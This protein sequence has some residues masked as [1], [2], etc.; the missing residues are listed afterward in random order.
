MT[1][2]D[3]SRIAT[4]YVKRYDGVR[5][6]QGRVTTEDDYNEGARL[7]AEHARQ[8]VLDVVGPSGSPDGGFGIDNPR[9]NAHG[10]LDFDIGAGV[11]YL[12]GLRLECEGEIYTQQL[13][14]LEQLPAERAPPASGRADLV[15]LMAWEQPVCAV[16][17]AELFE[18]ALGGPDT[19]TRTRLMRRVMLGAG[20]GGADCATAWSAALGTIEKTYGAWDANTG[21]CEPDTTLQVGFDNAGAK[22]D[23]CSPSVAGGYL[24]AE[25][26]AIRVQ[27]V[28]SSHITWGF[29][30]ASPLYR[31]TVGADP[32]IITLQTEPKDQAHWM[33]P[34]QTVEILA[35]SALLPNGEKLAETTGFLTTVAGGYDPDLHTLKLSTAVPGMPPPGFGEQW[36]ARDDSADLA[37]NGTY[38][39][40]RVWPRGS[41]T[42]SPAALPFATKAPVTLGHTG[43]Q[44]TLDGSVFVPGDFWVIAARPEDPSRVVPWDLLSGRKPQGIRRFFAPL[45]QIFW[46]VVAGDTSATTLD[47]CR[48]P[49][50][51]LTRRQTCCT[52]TVGDGIVSHG[53]YAVIQD[54]I[55]H[56]PPRGGCICIFAGTYAQDFRIDGRSNVRIEGCGPRTHITG[57][58]QSKNRAV[59]SIVDSSDI[60]LTDLAI[61]HAVRIPLQLVD[62]LEVQ[63]LTLPPELATVQGNA[64][65]Q[66]G[67][68]LTRIRLR[69]LTLESRDMSALVMAGGSVIDLCESEITLDALPFDFQFKSNAGRWPGIFIAADD[70]KVERNAIQA[71]S[72]TQR[73]PVTFVPPGAL[74]PAGLLLTVLARL[75]LGGIQIAGGSERVL[76]RRNAIIGG[77]GNG[78]TLGSI[79]YVPALALKAFIGKGDFLALSKLWTPATL[80]GHLSIDA[81]GCIQ[82]VPDP[83]PPN[84]PDGTPLVPVST[85]KLTDIVIEENDIEQMGLSGIAVARFFDM[86]GFAQ[87]ILVDRLTIRLNRIS[88]CLRVELPA[89]TGALAGWAAYGAIALALADDLLVQGNTIN[90]NGHSHLQPICGVFLV[91]GAGVSI[92]DNVIRDNGPRIA[93][94][95]AAASGL[96]GGIYLGMLAPPAEAIG[97]ESRPAARIL[98]N[99][100]VCQEGQALVIV[101]ASGAIEV[102]RNAFTSRGAA[103]PRIPVPGAG[104]APAAGPGLAPPW[105]AFGVTVVIVDVGLSSET[106]PAGSFANS[107]FVDA[108]AA[109]TV[110]PRGAVMFNDN[111]V[112]LDLSASAGS[113]F[114]SSVAL[115]SLDDVSAQDNQLAAW[116]NNA[117]LLTD[118]LVMAGSFRLVGNRL[119]E[120]MFKCL[121]SGL[122][123]G[124]LVTATLNQ[125]THCILANS[126]LGPLPQAVTPPQ[127]LSLIDA[128]ALLA[129]QP[130]LCANAGHAGQ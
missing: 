42:A 13:D 64:N 18:T 28:D 99:V 12:G 125:A 77:A 46:S 29:D 34:G 101:A 35:W 127:N 87:S 10:E 74:N 1:T 52:F 97:S 55:D 24:G 20:L 84:G 109:P 112:L 8:T 92:V 103:N 129:K 53:D 45:G 104:I 96:R 26:Q 90:A 83:P 89:I 91:G 124:V 82:Y 60:V 119:S 108:R 86:T 79:A 49:F 76:I 19:S 17:D 65:A 61:S 120:T 43:V 39:F 115:I 44:V 9:I 67:T 68:R 21:L 73:K 85:G 98:D 107:K 31:V 27:I 123:L 32:T 71:R 37:K 6:Q 75:P 88:Q 50:Q 130:P 78:I 41:D 57:A 47:D 62:R 36:Q 118:I 56:L 122:G 30:N 126:V 4:S 106:V 128:W 114:T 116:S 54:A 3:I 59:A 81:N 5:F 95:D 38:Y 100:V 22:D 51:P 2:E 63:A 102:S 113:L 66:G 80:A 69:H 16:E 33:L 14:W 105:A 94:F 48:T 25:N 15:W 117:V 58:P 121:L 23:L 11:F 110:L 93:S 72:Q 111:Q 40:M 7:F 70:V